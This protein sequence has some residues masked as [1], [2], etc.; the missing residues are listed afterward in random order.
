MLLVFF[1]LLLDSCSFYCASQTSIS[2]KNT[3]IVSWQIIQD[4]LCYLAYS[5]KNI[6][7]AAAAAISAGTC[8][9]ICFSFR[10]HD[11]SHWVTESSWWL[12]CEHETHC[13]CSPVSLRTSSS[14]YLTSWWRLKTFLFKASLMPDMMCHTACRAE[15]GLVFTFLYSTPQHCFVKVSLSRWAGTRRNI[16]PLT[17]MRKKKDSHREQDPLRGSSSPLWCFQPVR[18]LHL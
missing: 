12:Q 17:P 4:N 8:H 15:C 14:S 1:V 3:T 10:Q 18:V 7:L 2:R 9:S 6:A 11:G 5:V 16:H 13:K